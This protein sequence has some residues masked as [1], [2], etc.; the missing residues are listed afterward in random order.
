MGKACGPLAAA[1]AT[2]E[3]QRTGLS[4]QAPSSNINDVKTLHLASELQQIDTEL[5]ETVSGKDKI[6]VI[7]KMVLNETMAATVHRP[8]KVVAFN[9]DGIWRWHCEL[10]KQLEDVHIQGDSGGVTA[11]YG[12][13]F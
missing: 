2:K 1:S 10:S 11:T 12:A 3:I 5:S 8:L 7:T 13:H 6:M 9:A 4:V